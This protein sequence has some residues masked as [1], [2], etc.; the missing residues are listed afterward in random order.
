MWTSVGFGVVHEAVLALPAL[1]VWYLLIRSGEGLGDIG[2]GGRRMRTDLALLVPVMVIV[3]WVPFGLGDRLQHALGLTTLG[4]RVAP[5]LLT[6][7]ALVV[8]YAAAGISAGVL[9][10]FVVLGYLVHRLE[11]RGISTGWIVTIAVAVRVSYHLY[12]GWG[13]LPIAAWALVSVLAYR[14]VRRLLPFIVCHA[15]WD[16]TQIFRPL[17][18]TA[19][20]TLWWVALLAGLAVMIGWGRWSRGDPTPTPMV[21]TGPTDGGIPT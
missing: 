21:I 3:F 19:Y 5:I 9:E 18:P 15:A 10:E 12:Y 8:A 14:R 4:L 2:L 13:A 6:R 16:A 20:R 11:Q 17:Y 7:P 1:L